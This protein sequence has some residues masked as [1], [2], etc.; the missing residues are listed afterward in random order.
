ML[1]TTL[2]ADFNNNDK[3]DWKYIVREGVVWQIDTAPEGYQP[4]SQDEADVLALLKPEHRGKDEEQE[5]G[6]G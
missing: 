3:L 5:Q 1:K 4:Q 6:Q 2:P